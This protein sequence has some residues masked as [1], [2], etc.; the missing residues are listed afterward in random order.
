MKVS[1]LVAMIV[2][3]AVSASA[4]ADEGAALFKKSGC[5]VCHA[6]NKKLVG[7]AFSEVAKKYAGD[8]TAQARLEQKIRSG[9]S[10]SFGS[11]PMPPTGKNVSDESIKVLVTFALSQK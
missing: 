10:G 4:L 5:N 2:A 9:G 8:A 6:L 11:M 3:C 1:Y 7:P